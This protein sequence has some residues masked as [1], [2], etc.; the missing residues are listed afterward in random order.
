MADFKLIE[1][2]WEKFWEEH[3]EISRAEKSDEKSKKYVLVE[4]PYP[5]GSGLHIG[6]AFSFTGADVYARFQ[7]M[8]GYN[9][10]FPMGWDA[11][12]LPTENYAIKMKRRPQEITKE[13]TDH[14]R[15]QMKRLAFS[16]DW[17]REV[18]TTDPRYYKWTQWIFIQL[19]KKGLAYKKEMPINWCPS[20][21]IGLA[22]EEVVDGKCERC[23]AEVSRR[24]ISQWV[25]KITDYADK[26]IE[27]LKGTEFIEKVK[28]QQINWIGKSEG[29]KVK[30]L[31]SNDQFLDK[32]EK[33]YLEV[34][35]TRPDTLFGATFMVIAPEHELVKKLISEVAISKTK[36]EEIEN[37]LKD[38]R[39]KSDMERTELSKD[40][41]GV[42]SGLY[43]I[44]PVNNKQIPIWVSDFVL[45][46]YGTGA[47][48]SVPA[49][50][51]RDFAFAKKFNLEI[52]PVIEP[53][54]KDH[55]FEK[56]PYVDVDKGKIINSEPING[57]VPAEA[58]E[59]MIKWLEEKGIGKRTA[60]YHLRDWIF[61]RQHYWGEPIPMIHC[62]KCA[63][64]HNFQF[65]I[66]NFQSNSNDKNFNE[67]QNKLKEYINKTNISIEVLKNNPGWYPVEDETLPIVL[68]EVEAYEP[69]DD[70]KSPLS[71]IDSFV[72]CKCPVCGTEAE[73]ETDTM[74]NW[75]GSDWYFLGYILADKINNGLGLNDVVNDIFSSSQKELKY[76][77]PVDIYIGGDEHNVLH[78]LY[79]RFIYKFLWDL[80]VLPKESPEP[81]FKRISHGVIL[82]PD[83]QRM[84]KSRGNVI[85]PETVADKYGVD[86]VRMYLMF[87]GPF[88]STMAWNEK[89]LMGVKRFVDRF[90]E[91]DEKLNKEI[92]MSKLFVD[93]ENEYP[94]VKTI[95]N[96]TIKKVTEDLEQF[97]YNTAIASMMELINKLQ[98]IRINRSIKPIVDGK[99][100]WMLVVSKESIKKIIKLI[101]PLAPY[102]AEE[103]WSIVR[104]ENDAV[105]VHLS[106]W[107]KVDEK[108]L[109]EDEIS[110]PVAIN[111]KVRGQLIISNEELVINNKEKIIAKAKDLEQ[112]KKWV[113]E[114][115][116]VKEIY[117]PGKMVNL[118]IQ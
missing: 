71:K 68:P 115:K 93:S 103:M 21:K 110:L 97:K 29:A 20:C 1:N 40:K 75:A 65:S 27:G 16:F 23:G 53:T 76:W 66:F 6:H 56:E 72:K 87:M 78:L 118:V 39:K 51:E 94:E 41:T 58:F 10:M 101:A 61:S 102:M 55:N 17:E 28:Q 67:I 92:R 44:N 15:K 18:D 34:F 19:F 9:V 96:K 109:V 49:H 108:Y 100:N 24:N 104:D 4:F 106:G 38:A 11:F 43:A 62:H 2:K 83:N 117:V 37:Y 45:A 84:S 107:P 57:M 60:S 105:S 77:S 22:N 69:T 74:P 112:V 81:Y 47:I 33:Q 86:V 91:F 70:G 26:L 99:P 90:N 116:I 50:D 88:D 114:G 82:G 25:V 48:M 63:M 31:I 36:K 7:R 32:T 113:G 5:S 80:G 8:M 89:T 64:N 14:F 13:N 79:S 73:R 54:D 85:V 52:V 59:K 35:T 3:P 111:G 46:S 95:I 12:G 30:F 98:E 42:F